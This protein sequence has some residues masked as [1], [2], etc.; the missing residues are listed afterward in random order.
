MKIVK[1][2]AK[3]RQDVVGVKCVKEESGNTVVKP[4]MVK[5]RWREYMERLLNVEND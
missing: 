3:E 5:K 1:Q 2:L 4:G